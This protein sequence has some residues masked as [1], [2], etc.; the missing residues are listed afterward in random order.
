MIAIASIKA[1]AILQVDAIRLSA[2]TRYSAV[3]FLEKFICSPSTAHI[4]V[5][6]LCAGTPCSEFRLTKATLSFTVL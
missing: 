1:M 2:S 6:L 3:M 5:F 4:A